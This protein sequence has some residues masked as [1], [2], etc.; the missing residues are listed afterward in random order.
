MGPNWRVS[1][2]AEKQS[3]LP[4]PPGMALVQKSGARE[5]ELD[6]VNMQ[7][8]IEKENQA[9][10]AHAMKMAMQPAMGIVQTAFML[11]MSGK[12][13]QIFSIYATG[14]ALV[15]PIKAISN[16]EVMFGKFS[17]DKGVDTK[18]PKL[19]FIL[20][21]LV[22]LSVGLYKCHT[23][24]LLPLTSVDWLWTLPAKQVSEIAGS[25]L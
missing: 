12:S 14:N 5:S 3:L 6:N 2:C 11:W 7:L 22:A 23:M 4:R 10:Q 16:I 21:Q 17:K 18:L 25:P 9:K 1:L 24:G 19:V 15:N 13:I 8:D 20:V